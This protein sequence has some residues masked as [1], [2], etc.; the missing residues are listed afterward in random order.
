M[1]L[2]SYLD[3]SCDELSG[4]LECPHHAQIACQTFPTLTP[5]TLKNF[6]WAHLGGAFTQLS[7]DS[8]I[9]GMVSPFGLVPWY[10]IVGDSQKTW[11]L[12]TAALHAM[13]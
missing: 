8:F 13:P 11:S 9:G 1:G 3:S 10:S 4:I 12:K 7:R 5:L 6:H 2:T